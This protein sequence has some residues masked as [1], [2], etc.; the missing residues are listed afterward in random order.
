[1]KAL[2]YL[3]ILIMI[4]SAGCAPAAPISAAQLHATATPR[5]KPTHTPL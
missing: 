5:L 1:M 2:W 3:P 4:I